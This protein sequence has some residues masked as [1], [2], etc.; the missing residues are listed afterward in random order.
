MLLSSDMSAFKAAN[1]GAVLE[2]FVRWH[3]A[4]AGAE[5]EGSTGQQ[6]ANRGVPAR[7]C[8]QVG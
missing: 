2:D 8:G 5:D 6:G 1:P 7:L 3:S 4:G